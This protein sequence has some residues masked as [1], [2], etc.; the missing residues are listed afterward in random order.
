MIRLLLAALALLAVP[1]PPATATDGGTDLP[2]WV[3]LEEKVEARLVLVPVLVT[4]PDGAP[5]LDLHA[6][7]FQVRLDRDEADPDQAVAE[8]L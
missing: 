1:G 4:G 3:P 5:L 8:I 6:S 2:L 7:D